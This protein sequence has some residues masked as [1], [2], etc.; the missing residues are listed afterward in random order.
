M[1]VNTK[2]E[3][4][5]I[6]DLRACAQSASMSKNRADSIVDQVLEAVGQW[7]TFAQQASLPE[8]LVE[9]IQHHHHLDL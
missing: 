8:P 5:T 2:R 3:N 9:A 1:S 6:E 4:F 7:R